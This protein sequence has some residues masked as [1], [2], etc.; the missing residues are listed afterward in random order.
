MNERVGIVRNHT[1][2]LEPSQSGR[3]V[4]EDD[5]ACERFQEHLVR[6][7]PGLAEMMGRNARRSAEQLSR[8]ADRS[9]EER[10]RREGVRP[11][12]PEGAPAGGASEGDGD[13]ARR[14]AGDAAAEGAPDPDLEA[15]EARAAAAE[16]R[17]RALEA[18]ADLAEA[19]ARAARERKE[20]RS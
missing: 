7:T 15:L 11:S 20:G 8:E 19:R 18:K 16:A 17:A 6:H 3:R 10:L 4:R 12:R 1:V 5:P 13:V 9:Y 2:C 14:G